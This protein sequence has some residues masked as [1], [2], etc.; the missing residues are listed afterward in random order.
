MAHPKTRCRTYSLIHHHLTPPTPSH[1]T[2]SHTHPPTRSG[3]IGDPY[4]VLFNGT[5]VYFTGV[6][7]YSLIQEGDGQQLNATFSEVSVCV[8]GGGGGKGLV[9][10]VVLVLGERV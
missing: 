1:T 10:R 7:T 9:M 5:R 3:V 4:L 8:W 6:G 2:P